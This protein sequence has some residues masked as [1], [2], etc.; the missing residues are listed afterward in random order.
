MKRIH[1][2]QEQRNFKYSSD[3]QTLYR[4]GKGKLYVYQLADKD[5]FGPGEFYYFSHTRDYVPA[6]DWYLFN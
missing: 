3:G 1:I 4:I 6:R 5:E 2:S